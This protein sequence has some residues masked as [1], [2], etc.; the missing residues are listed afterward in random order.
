M[1]SDSDLDYLSQV[2]GVD[3]HSLKAKYS[4]NVYKKDKNAYVTSSNK[5]GN[6]SSIQKETP[7]SEEKSKEINATLSQYHI[8]KACNGL[9]IIKTLYNHMMLEKTCFIVAL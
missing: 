6:S 9:G 2:S 5:N 3:F 7:I 4:G 8:C 1:T